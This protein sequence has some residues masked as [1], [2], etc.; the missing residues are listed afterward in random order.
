LREQ[1]R[2]KYDSR[3]NTTAADQGILDPAEVAR[4]ILRIIASDMDL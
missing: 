1:I 4:V 2:A 3:M